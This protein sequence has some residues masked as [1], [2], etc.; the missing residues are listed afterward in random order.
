[1]SRRNEPRISLRIDMLSSWLVKLYASLRKPVS[2]QDF[3]HFVAVVSLQDDRIV[4]RGPATRA[5]CLEF[6]C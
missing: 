2:D 5:V 1:M 3:F 4:L 6:R